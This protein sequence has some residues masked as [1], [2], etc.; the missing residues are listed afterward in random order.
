[1]NYQLGTTQVSGYLE[2]KTGRS[3]PP[4]TYLSELNLDP[5]ERLKANN[6]SII[7]PHASMNSNNLR[8]ITHIVFVDNAS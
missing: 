1:M 5:V 7:T 8:L 4:A 6:I 3:I 2:A